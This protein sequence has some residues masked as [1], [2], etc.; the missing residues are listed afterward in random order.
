MKIVQ[1][2]N[3]TKRFG[4]IRAL[5]RVNLT[6][7]EGHVYGLL[8]RNG[9]GKTT[10]MSILTGQNFTDDGSVRVFGET[11]TENSR[12]TRQMCFIRENQKYPDEATPASV[13][14]SAAWLYPDWD[15]S[16]SSRLSER[17]DIPMSRSMKKL[18]RGQ[19]SAVGVTV[20]LACRAPITFFDEPYLGLDAYARD[21][22][23]RE[24]LEEISC[25][26]RTVVISSHLID[27]I[28]SLIDHVL[29]LDGGKLVLDMDAESLR[30]SSFQVVGPYALV[31]DFIGGAMVIRRESLGGTTRATI[32]KELSSED[33]TRGKMQHL[34]VRP[35]ALNDLVVSLGGL[36]GRNQ[37]AA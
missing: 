34:E 18:S 24:L 12:I 27:E 28:A 11:V 36:R 26:P 21:I 7:E 30:S 35:T 29:L 4:K 31:E 17:L 20:G 10:L 3:L 2:R 15:S 32:I 13:F 33:L 6:L 5:D 9:A 19:F 25:R 1:T 23:Y 8:G 16:L 37:D 22:F 14:R